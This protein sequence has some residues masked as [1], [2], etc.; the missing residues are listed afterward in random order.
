MPP[1]KQGGILQPNK[2]KIQTYFTLSF[3]LYYELAAF[4]ILNLFSVAYF[5][6]LLFHK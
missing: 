2:Y 6:L 5:G 4:R 1:G 3:H